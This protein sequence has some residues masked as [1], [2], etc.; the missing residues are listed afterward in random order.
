MSCGLSVRGK[1]NRELGLVLIGNL[2]RRTFIFSFT[3]YKLE[4]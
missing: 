2:G 4:Y 1:A 3:D